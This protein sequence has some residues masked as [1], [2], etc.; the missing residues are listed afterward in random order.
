MERPKSGSVVQL[1]S[2][3]STTSNLLY[4]MVRASQISK[5][6]GNEELVQGAHLDVSGPDAENLDCFFGFLQE[7]SSGN[8]V[9]LKGSP[10]V[11]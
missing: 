4:E 10:G 6:W 1:D 2:S 11:L 8:S 7:N 9:N 5:S 3:H